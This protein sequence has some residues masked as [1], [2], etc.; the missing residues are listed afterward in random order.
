VTGEGFFLTDAANGVQFKK[1]P[2][3]SPVQM[4]WTDPAHHNAFLVRPNPDG[5]VTS[6]SMNMFGNVSPQPASTTP[7]GYRALAYWASQEGCGSIKQLDAKTCPTVWNALGAWHDANQDGIAQA[8]EIQTLDSA[9]IDR[10]S[11]NYHESR[12]VDQYGNLFRY[13]SEILEDSAAQENRCYDV[14]LVVD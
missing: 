11:L 3:S 12:H 6:I 10:I 2:L 1:G 7:N 9:G 5:S 13:T 14:F 4:A 8:E